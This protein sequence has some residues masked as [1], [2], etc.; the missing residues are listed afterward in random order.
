MKSAEERLAQSDPDD[1]SPYIPASYET[2]IE[3]IVAT[4]FHGS[5][6]VWRGFKVKMAGSVAA[7]SLLTALGI[8]ALNTAGSALPVLGFAAASAQK[9]T[10]APAANSAS[11]MMM[12]INANYQFTGAANFSTQASSG[13]AY[14]LSAPSDGPSTLAQAASVLKIDV[15]PSSTSDNGQS[16]TASGA[17]FSGWLVQEAGYASWGFANNAPQPVTSPT[18]SVAVDVS[19]VALSY[20]HRLGTFELGVPTVDAVPSDPQSPVSVT[21]PILVSG[22]TTSLSYNFTFASNGDLAS[23]NGDSFTLEP[24]GNYPLLSPSSAVGQINSQLGVGHGL[25]NYAGAGVASGAGVGSSS[26]GSPGS[27]S[28]VSGPATP[29]TPVPAGSGTGAVATTTAP[30]STPPPPPTTSSGGPVTSTPS[31]P[32]VPDTTPIDSTPTTIPAPTLVNLTAVSS[33]Y[34][35][36]TMADGSAMLLPV[37]VYVGNIVGDASYQVTFQ[38]VP[39]DPSLIHLAAV[40]PSIY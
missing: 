29:T 3:R 32:G 21:V 26:P 2:M 37:Y 1:A 39:I 15:G 23:A 31:S 28:G 22:V 11:G 13:Q 7:A 19:A 33:Q 24:A 36:F 10:F 8:T 17:Q 35:V 38:V 16:F 6:T 4:P 30:G 18:S 14:T 34:D 5:S 20:A 12:R 40:R 9:S 27:S 25:M